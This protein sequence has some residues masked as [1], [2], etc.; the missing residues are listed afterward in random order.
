MGWQSFP[1]TT[2]SAAGSVDWDFERR[3]RSSSNA[4]LPFFSV[5]WSGA[6]VGLPGGSYFTHE[7]L[8]IGSREL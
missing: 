5:L 1:L 4:D 7:G 2:G 8:L 6:V 3:S